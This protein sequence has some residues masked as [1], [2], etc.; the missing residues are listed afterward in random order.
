MTL[1]GPKEDLTINCLIPS[2]SKI[3]HASIFKSISCAY[4]EVGAH[5]GYMSLIVLYSRLTL[6]S[7]M[8]DA[9]N[10]KHSLKAL[11]PENIRNL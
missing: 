3:V 6:G 7:K 2:C 11:Q 5:L 1:N 10:M 8:L 4:F 9:S